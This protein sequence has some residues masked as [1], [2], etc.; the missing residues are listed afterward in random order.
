M[1]RG[2]RESTGPSLEAPINATLAGRLTA[3]GTVAA[4]VLTTAVGQSQE[5]AATPADQAARQALQHRATAAAPASRSL[6][7]RPLH[8]FGPSALSVRRSI[9]VD[10]VKAKQRPRVHSRA[11]PPRVRERPARPVVRL[12]RKRAV[13]HRPVASRIV[14]RAVA[15][16][17]AV[18]RPVTR[19]VVRKVS[20]PAGNPVVR[21]AESQLGR[22][23]VKGGTGRGGWDC[24]G[25]TR[26]AYARVGK[27]LA[28][29]ASRQHGAA[30]RRGQARPG[31]L[32]KWGDYHVG[33][34]V[35]GGRVIHAPK[36]GDRVKRAPLWG[37]Y[38]IVRV[39]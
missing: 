3:V 15:P 38:R 34:Y 7:R 16:R 12:A 5:P 4:I 27:R 23:Y 13:P 31:D 20:R 28:H 18:A 17:R 9:G 26:A 21:F 14:P 32:V 36:P 22:P 29:K 8:V 33:I 35:G 19:K 30:V 2:A 37:S 1:F 25:L 24:S 10:P 11:A 39:R 6:V